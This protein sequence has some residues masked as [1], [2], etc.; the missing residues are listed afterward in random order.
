[1]S[2]SSDEKCKNLQVASPQM[3]FLLI[4]GSDDALMFLRVMG[5]EWVFQESCLTN[6]PAP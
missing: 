3:T 6:Q 4:D 1:M 2:Q 5:H